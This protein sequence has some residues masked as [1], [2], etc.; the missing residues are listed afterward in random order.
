MKSDPQ[1]DASLRVGRR[2]SPPYPSSTAPIPAGGSAD[3]SEPSGLWAKVQ[4]SMRQSLQPEKR[5]SSEAALLLAAA[6]PGHSLEFFMEQT[7]RMEPVDW[8]SFYRLARTHRLSLMVEPRLR[9][10]PRTPV[11][12]KILEQTRKEY[13]P[14]LRQNLAMDNLTVQV[15]TLLSSA[16]L[17]TLLFR[18]TPLVRQ[19]FGDLGLQAVSQVDLLVR[20]EHVGRAGEILRSIGFVAEKR[21]GN[22]ADRCAVD[23]KRVIGGVTYRVVLHWDFP[24]FASVHLPIEKVWEQ[25]IPYS[26]HAAHDLNWREW[27]LRLNRPLLYALSPEFQFLSAFAELARGQFEDWLEMANL[28]Q[29]AEVYQSLLD[30]DQVADHFES[31]EARKVARRGFAHARAWGLKPPVEFSKRFTGSSALGFFR[32]TAPAKPAVRPPNPSDFELLIVPAWTQ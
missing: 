9:A 28:C 30:W 4:S 32:P 15:A 17:P 23:M 2:L 6:S 31:L 16:G 12:Q 29:I 3:F 14:T 11:L 19:F 18:G 10:L 21:P 27:D 13:F 26:H 20:R 8:A 5:V 1:P 24:P 22:I 7:R 25:A